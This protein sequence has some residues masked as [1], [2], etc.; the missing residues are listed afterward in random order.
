MELQMDRWMD[1]GFF[2][3]NAGPAPVCHGEEKA[4]LSVYVPTLTCGLEI[5]IITKR[6]SLGDKQLKVASSVGGEFLSFVLCIKNCM[7]GWMPNLLKKSHYLLTKM[8]LFQ[9]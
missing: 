6:T 1:W 3:S 7:D 8:K 5:W 9:R 4:K 2:C